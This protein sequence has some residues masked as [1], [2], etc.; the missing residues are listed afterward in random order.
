MDPHDVL[1]V[2][3]EGNHD[4]SVKGHG[5]DETVV[6]VRMLTDEIDSSGRDGDA[7]L[8]INAMNLMKTPASRVAEIGELENWT[9]HQ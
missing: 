1:M 2:G 5:K 6:I 3:H 8:D 7:R 4:V 9:R